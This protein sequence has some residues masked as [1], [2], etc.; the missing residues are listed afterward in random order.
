M[1]ETRIF[2]G[3]QK[4]GFIAKSDAARREWTIGKP[5]LK[6]WA[7]HD[8]CRDPA[9]PD[10][11]FA[12]VGSF[13]YG[14]T[15]HVSDDRGETWR[16]L[17]SAPRYAEGAGRE[18][19]TIWSLS[20][21]SADEPG[22]LFAGVEEA[23]LFVTRDGGKSW[24]EFP[25]LND[26]PTRG[27]W[28]PGGGGLCLHRILTDPSN[29]RRIW[30]AISAVGV[31][32]SDDGGESWQSKNKGIPCAIEARDAKDAIGFCPHCLCLDPQD[33]N[34]LYRQDHLGVFRSTDGGDNWVRL[35]GGL[36][37][38]FGFPITVDPRTGALFIIPLQSDEY[39]MPVDG[40]LKVWR[41]TD[42]MESWHPLSAGL[43]QANNYAT[44]LRNAMDVDGMEICGV[45]FG[46]S[47]GQVFASADRGESWSQLPAILPRVQSVTAAVWE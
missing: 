46:N 22:T 45:Y 27:E 21:G 31:F 39:R 38:N 33:P 4:G 16:Q 28:C 34:T 41:S 24:S 42:R 29:P 6:G 20:T 44:I 18:V 13:V 11:L 10:R 43:P 7:I 14:A 12:A 25:A 1:A 17:E 47:A 37:A 9:H 8:I 32:R 23:G 3:T 5:F 2:I 15:V 26:H 35:E 40:A 36:P 19:K 30:I